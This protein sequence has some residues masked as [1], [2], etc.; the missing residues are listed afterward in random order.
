MSSQ[1]KEKL[2]EDMSRLSRM[3]NKVVSQDEQFLRHV[4]SGEEDL[5]ILDLACGACNEADT[6]TDFFLHL[7]DPDAPLPPPAP[8]G[9]AGGKGKPK[10]RSKGKTG[11]PKARLTGMD[12]RAREIADAKRRFQA[13]VDQ[14]TGAE[15]DYEF[16]EGDATQ[17]DAHKELPGE[18]DLIFIR[19]QNF[20]NGERTWEE[21]YHKALE[22]LSPQ[23]RL[24]ITSYFDREHELALNSFRN[25]GGELLVTERNLESRE[26]PTPGKSIDRHVAIIK[27]QD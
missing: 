24:I 20:W 5:Q 12:V 26:L 27:R 19:H 1:E 10:R 4:S 16:L 3:L 25:Q 17:L 22:K 7:R 13:K 15:T 18:F 14:Q 9:K 21:I 6:L 11:K 2:Q 8:K 23:G